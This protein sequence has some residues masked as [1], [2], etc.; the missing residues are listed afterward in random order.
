MPM[1]FAE[2]LVEAVRKKFRLGHTEALKKVH[3]GMN[4]ARIK[5]RA[6]LRVNWEL[7]NGPLCPSFPFPY[8]RTWC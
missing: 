6:R 2:L 1:R 8:F 5:A 3:G 7:G 4:E